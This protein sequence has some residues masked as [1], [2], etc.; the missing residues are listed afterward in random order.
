VSKFAKGT[1]G[2]PHGRALGSR[3]RAL[4]WLDRIGLDAASDIL[5]AVT[6]RA[7]AGDPECARLILSR[8]W[9]PVRGRP[10]S[11]Q[12]PRIASVR[13]VTKALAAI[14][15]AAAEGRITTSEAAEL[16]TLIESVRK[17]FELAEIERRLAALEAAAGRS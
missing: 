14:T 12:L 2:N 15:G 5:A 16:A 6:A 11:L 8:V 1:S 3:N 13:D 4:A 9:P 10:V 7:K 17:S